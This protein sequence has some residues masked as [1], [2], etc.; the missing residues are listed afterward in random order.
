MV[1]VEPDNIENYITISFNEKELEVMKLA[2]TMQS[3]LEG[4]KVDKAADEG[5]SSLVTQVVRANRADL[6]MHI[7]QYFKPDQDIIIKKAD[8]LPIKRGLEA[9]RDSVRPELLY[10]LDSAIKKIEAL[11]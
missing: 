6:T 7:V 2:C 8:L 11:L 4:E 9:Y 3:L 5:I 10:S 1:T